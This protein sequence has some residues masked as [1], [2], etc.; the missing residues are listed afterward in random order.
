MA[1]I[2]YHASHEQFAPAELLSYVEQAQAVGFDCAM[3]SDHFHPWSERQGHSGFAWSWLGA[4]LQATTMSLGVVNSPSFRYHP[5]VIAQAAATLA[6]MYPGRFW[7]AVGSGEAINEAMTGQPWPDKARRNARLAEAVA[8]IRA[9]WAGEEVWHRG[10]LVTQGARLFTLP[11]APVP[12]YA[13]ALSVETAK[14]AGSW[15]DGLITISASHDQ[16]QRIIDAFREG[17]GEGKPLLL[18]VKLSFAPDHAQAVHG[19]HQQ[20]RTNVLPGRLGQELATVADFDAAASLVRPQDLVGQVRISA[21][22]G[23]H[24]AWLEDDLQQGFDRLYLHNVNRQQRV[25]IDTF[26]SLVLPRLR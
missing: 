3:C 13:A 2:G 17:G 22:P 7:L 20:W 21:D 9:L 24:A 12:M 6:Q 1:V 23:Q 11:A 10:T 8:I 15:A 19:A 18:Q 25:F 16:Q 4:A 14:W 26:A 5:A